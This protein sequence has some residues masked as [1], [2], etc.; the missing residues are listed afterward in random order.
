MIQSSSSLRAH[1]KSRDRLCARHTAVWFMGDTN[2]TAERVHAS[3]WTTKVSSLVN[4]TEMVV[5]VCERC[6]SPT[7]V[8]AMLR[9]HIIHNAKNEG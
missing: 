2:T 3:L 4:R 8:G 6:L 1:R 5:R 9:F 7:S